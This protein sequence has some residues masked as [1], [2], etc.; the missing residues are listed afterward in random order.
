MI[1]NTED[2]TEGKDYQMKDGDYLTISVVSNESTL[3]GRFLGILSGH[4]EE[5]RDIRFCRWNCWENSPVI[6]A[7]SR[8][9]NSMNQAQITVQAEGLLKESGYRFGEDSYV[10]IMDFIHRFDFVAGNARLEDNADGF[11]AVYIGNKVI[12]VNVNLTL[13]Q[14]RLIIAHE[15][16]YFV[17]YANCKETYLHWNKRSV[18]NRK[19]KLAG[20]FA[21]EL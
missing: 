15:F 1:P 7:E 20:F 12:G 9:N 5:M 2:D 21:R 19:E 13:A 8:N 14:K 16:A 10:N 18:V 3:A 11:L 4:P 6:S 17:L